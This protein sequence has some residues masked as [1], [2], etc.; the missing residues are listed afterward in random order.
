MEKESVF[1]YGDNIYSKQFIDH[2]KGT[3]YIEKSDLSK[4]DKY[5]LLADDKENMNFYYEHRK[6]FKDKEVFLKHSFFQN[7]ILENVNFFSIEMIIA[8]KF[9]KEHSLINLAFENGKVK[10]KMN[11]VLVGFNRL[12]QQVL[13]EGLMVNIYDAKQVVNYHLFGDHRLFNLSHDKSKE[14][15]IIYHDECCL[16]NKDLLENADIVLFFGLQ[17][18]LYTIM[19]CISKGNIVLFSDSDVNVELFADHC[20]GKVNKLNLSVFN[21]VEGVCTTENVFNM[22]ALAK[23]KVVNHNFSSAYNKEDKRNAQ[24]QWNALSPLYKGSNISVVDFFECTIIKLAEK[25][26]GKPYVQVTDEE[27]EKYSIDVFAELEHIQWCRFYL[28]HNWSYSPITDKENRKHNC[29]VPFET[30][31][32]EEQYKDTVQLKKIRELL[33]GQ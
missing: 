19:S 22:D 29:I 13:Y 5:V 27:F 6:E 25:L 3:I 24:Q 23:A 21:Y 17:E 28:Y 12:A 4:A 18:K 8:R 11:V 31:S 33:K 7:A 1:V 30:L 15:N 32:K 16:E 14:L 26:S 10:E 20:Y 9:W 2:Y